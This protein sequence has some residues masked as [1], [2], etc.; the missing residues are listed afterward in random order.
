MTDKGYRNVYLPE[1]RL[2]HYESISLGRPEQAKKRDT[3]EFDAAK[4][5]F[6]KTWHAYIAHDPAIN[7]NISRD[8]A[9]LDIDTEIKRYN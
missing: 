6:K 9:Y 5:L 7:P 8:N 3:T 2:I 4:D 1:V